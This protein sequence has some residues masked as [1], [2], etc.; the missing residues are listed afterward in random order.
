MF[1][2][3]Q[4]QQEW[5]GSDHFSVVSDYRSVGSTAT[6]AVAQPNMEPEE[7]KANRQS[8]YHV[9]SGRETSQSSLYAGAEE[10]FPDDFTVNT[11]NTQSSTSSRGFRRFFQKK[12]RTKKDKKKSFKK[13]MKRFAKWITGRG[14][15]KDPSYD[16]QAANFFPQPT[17]S[18]DFPSV[19]PDDLS[20]T[21]D[22]VSGGQLKGQMR[23]HRNRRYADWD[24]RSVGNYSASYSVFSQ[25]SA[26]RDELILQRA[27]LVRS[28]SERIL[29]STDVSSSVRKMR[30]KN[31]ETSSVCSSASAPRP[32]PYVPPFASQ[33]KPEGSY[34]KDSRRDDISVMSQVSQEIELPSYE[35][36]YSGALSSPPASPKKPAKSILKSDAQETA[37]PVPARGSF[38]SSDF[39][40][41][42]FEVALQ[43]PP[44]RDLSSDEE[45]ITSEFRSPISGFQSVP[46]DRWSPAASPT[47]ELS[48]S[49]GAPKLPPRS[50]DQDDGSISYA[51]PTALSLTTTISSDESKEDFFLEET[52]SLQEDDAISY[53]SQALS[54]VRSVV[55][56]LLRRG[57]GSGRVRF[58]NVE[59]REYER[60]LGDNPSCSS[61]PPISIGWCYSLHRDM[62]LE[63]YERVRPARR[64]KRQFYLSAAK[65][66]NFLAEWDVTPEEMHQARREVT[67][68]QYCREKAILN[69]KRKG[70][71]MVDAQEAALAVKPQLPSK[72]AMVTVASS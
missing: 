37:A 5:H 4:D 25:E 16:S 45:D 55:E 60:A 43:S 41:E 51:G 1:R 3:A 22:F 49:T 71:A 8:S 58:G 17:P 70:E 35:T 24:S 42:G 47:H 28:N 18:F 10:D 66:N 62:A 52:R 59:V 12:S 50:F 39:G 68:I 27:A 72:N 40:N 30:I 33:M 2:L 15:A 61:G 32:L 34:Q 54:E 11:Q 56:S 20:V 7:A 29:R 38:Q 46:R 69:M 26:D 9:S 21:S 23:K 44:G 14:G 31:L 67:Y 57:N 53:V 13:R 65:R 48:S 19:A 64:N 63:D 6:P 36:I